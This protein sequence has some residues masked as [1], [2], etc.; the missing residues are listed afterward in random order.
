MSLDVSLSTLDGEVFDANIT[1]NL[2]KMAMAA[3]IY[4]ALWRPDENNLNTAGQLIP[5]LEDGLAK[6]KFNPAK[7]KA[8]NPPNGWGNY[9]DFIT[10][11][12]AYLTACRKYPEASVFVSR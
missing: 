4:E 6:M 1:H 3:G 9:D 12:E 2:N 10:W 8:L 5:L 11:I 7:F